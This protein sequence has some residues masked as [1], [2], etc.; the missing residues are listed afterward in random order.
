MFNKST[1]LFERRYSVVK[2]I[3]NNARRFGHDEDGSY[4]LEVVLWFPALLLAFQFVT[5]ST[6]ALMHQQNFYNVARDASR[7]VALGQRTTTEAEDYIYDTLH[8]ISAVS[9]SVTIVN[10]FVTTEVSAPLT[11]LTNLSGSFIDRDLSAQV[12][13]WVENYEG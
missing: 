4:T 1:Q 5:D 13:M 10:N 9:A 2:S 11:N 6:M 12:S 8:N 7:M 3:L